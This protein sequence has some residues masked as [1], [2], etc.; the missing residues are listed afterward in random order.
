MS[1]VTRKLTVDVDKEKEL[2][3]GL[4]RHTY[5][6]HHNNS[7]SPAS[8]PPCT[9][10]FTHS[11]RSVFKKLVEYI[12]RS[13]QAIISSVRDYCFHSFTVLGTISR[14]L[15][16]LNLKSDKRFSRCSRK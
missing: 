7:V 11:F 2:E 16:I 5:D 13:F 9:P 10:C 6:Q 3:L 4:G 15:E 8:L 12:L 14:F 1:E